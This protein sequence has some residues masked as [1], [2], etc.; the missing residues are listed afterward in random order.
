MSCSSPPQQ[1]HPKL[2]ICQIVA[3]Q[4][5]YYLALGGMLAVGHSL[6][7]TDLSLDH[8]F[9]DKHMNAQSATGWVGITAAVAASLVG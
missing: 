7:G 1:W 8:F 6:F 9:T 4:C 5:T 2:I 3:L